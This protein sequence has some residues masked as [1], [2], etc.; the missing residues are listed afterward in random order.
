M[1]RSRCPTA[2]AAWSATP[3]RREAASTC[4]ATARSCPVYG[5]Q[6]RVVPDRRHAGRHRRAGRARRRA[7]H[8]RRPGF[9]QRPHARPPAR[10]GAGGALPRAQLRRH[11]QGRA[12]ARPRRTCCRCCATPGASSSSPPSKPS[13]TTS[14]S[15]STRV[16]RAPTS[17]PSSTRCGDAR[18]AAGAD[19]RRLHAV[20][21][22]RRLSGSAPD[23]RGPGPG[24]GRG[25]DSARD[26]PAAAGRAR[27]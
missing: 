27:A 12:P 26:P 25:V 14:S 15:A 11:H 5:G 13:T 24:G 2:P 17:S 1:R 16:T 20:D 18:T 8:L 6:F 9:L 19:L 22:A 23:H 21:D 4:A 7:H 10:R 3:R